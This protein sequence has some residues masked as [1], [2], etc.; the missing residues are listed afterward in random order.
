MY[1]NKFNISYLYIFLK[2]AS[3]LQGYK[4]TD[5]AKQKI[6]ERFKE[7]SNHLFGGKH[8]DA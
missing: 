7:K 5:I 8:H 2:N 3:S 6:V 1:R 4:H